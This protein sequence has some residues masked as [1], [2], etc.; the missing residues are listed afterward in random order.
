MDRQFYSIVEAAELLKLNPKR[1]CNAF[2]D[3]RLDGGICKRGPH[4]HRRI[5]Q[6]YLQEIKR[7]L[8]NIEEVMEQP[9]AIETQT[10]ETKMDTEIERPGGVS[11]VL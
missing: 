4:G 10:G 8:G 5:P 3:Q 9:L 11:E 7:I 2:F 6:S 1:I